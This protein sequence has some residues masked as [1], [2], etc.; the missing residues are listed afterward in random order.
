MWKVQVYLTVKAQSWGSC[1]SFHVSLFYLSIFL[2][3]TCPVKRDK[4]PT[5]CTESVQ[6]PPTSPGSPTKLKSQRDIRHLVLAWTDKWMTSGGVLDPLSLFVRYFSPHRQ[7]YNRTSFLLG[8]PLSHSTAVSLSCPDPTPMAE[9][10]KGCHNC[11]FFS[12]P[13]SLAVIIYWNE[14]LDY[15]VWFI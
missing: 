1:Q 6:H 5:F 8:L 7:G 15:V 2:C 14:S 4:A 10:V 12:E 11:S 13:S 3:K 9:S